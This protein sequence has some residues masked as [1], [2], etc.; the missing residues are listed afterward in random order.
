[1]YIF[2]NCNSRDVLVSSNCSI[3]YMNTLNG[4][5]DIRISS[6]F[7]VM[8]ITSSF[9]IGAFANCCKYVSNFETPTYVQSN[10]TLCM[11][12]HILYNIH[13]IYH[14]TGCNVTN[15]AF[16][17]QKPKAKR[18]LA[19]HGYFHLC[20]CPKPARSRYIIGT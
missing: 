15:A 14:S 11:M 3:V 20:H 16:L 19:L 12:Y 17:R 18:T 2:S 7:D 9:D 13:E 10:R 1:M 5:G 4:L 6:S 8:S